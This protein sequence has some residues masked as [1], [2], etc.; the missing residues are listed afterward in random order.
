MLDNE[1]IHQDASLIN[2]T[3]FNY[4]IYFRPSPFA[5]RPSNIFALK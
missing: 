4:S 2:F 3:G 1:K 5:N